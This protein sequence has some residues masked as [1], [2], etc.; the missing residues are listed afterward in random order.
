MT[1]PHQ[2]FLEIFQPSGGL[3]GPVGLAVLDIPEVGSEPVVCGSDD[4]LV[5]L[6]DSSK[7]GRVLLQE[8]FTTLFLKTVVLTLACRAKGRFHYRLAGC[9]DFN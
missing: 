7:A 3:R 1:F 6:D 5:S 9:L 4:K 8:A 2:I